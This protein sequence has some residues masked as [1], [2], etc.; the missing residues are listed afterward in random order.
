MKWRGDRGEMFLSDS[1][2]RDNVTRCELALDHDGRVLALEVATLANLGAWCSAVGPLVPTM[3]G[4]RIRRRNFIRPQDLPFTNH[5]GVT[6][7]S[8]EFESTM[9]LALER[10]DWHGFPARRQARRDGKLRGMGFG[11]YI[12][13]SGGGAEEEARLTLHEDGRADVVVGTYSHG[14]GHETAYKQILGEVLGLDF[15]L[16]RITQGDTE[17]VKFGGGTGGSRSSQMGGIAIL[18][19]GRAVAERGVAIAA[20]VAGHR[21]GVP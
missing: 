9:E 6:M 18:R 8:G 4:G 5:A 3:A 15:E 11:Y 21:R 17:H 12:E 16:I 10:S 7:H 19:A 14:Q 13:S 20:E 2:G 1:H